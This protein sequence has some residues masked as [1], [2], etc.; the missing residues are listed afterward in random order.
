M[1]SLMGS[2]H[3][4]NNCKGKSSSSLAADRD[5]LSRMLKPSLVAVS[6]TACLA[7]ALFPHRYTWIPKTSN[8]VT[9][10]QLLQIW[11]MLYFI[12]GRMFFL[13]AC[14]VMKGSIWLYIQGGKPNSNFLQDILNLGTKSRYNPTTMLQSLLML[15]IMFKIPHTPANKDA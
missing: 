9:D 1:A 7:S 15:L 2:L 8:I 5:P 4:G 13:S 10:L 3:P 14:V 12:A 11:I 6:V